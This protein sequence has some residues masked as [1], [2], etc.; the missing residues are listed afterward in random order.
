MGG[1]GEEASRKFE[2]AEVGQFRE[3]G[4]D[5]LP[6]ITRRKKQEVGKEM[7][8]FWNRSWGIKI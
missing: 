2:S 6:P 4:A 8:A 3:N 1:E 7:I 5:I